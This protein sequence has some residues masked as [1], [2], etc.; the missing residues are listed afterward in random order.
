MPPDVGPLPGPEKY[1]IGELVVTSYGE[2]RA[3][4]PWRSCASGIRT[5]SAM[6]K[7]PVSHVWYL[8]VHAQ[9]LSPPVLYSIAMSYTRAST[10]AAEADGAVAPSDA[11]WSISSWLSSQTCA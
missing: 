11:H 1:T 5:G 7:S 2:P 6:Q 8:S 10:N 3:G 9:R 4:K